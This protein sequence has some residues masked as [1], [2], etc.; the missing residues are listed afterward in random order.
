MDASGTGL[1]GSACQPPC[2]TK[3]DCP[4]P[5]GSYTAL[6]TCTADSLCLL[7]CALDANLNLGT[8][9]GD[10]TCT[11]MIDATFVCLSP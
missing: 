8:C 4:V 2:Q 7:D 11:P 1:L 10:M 9:P 3:N 6:V 5:A